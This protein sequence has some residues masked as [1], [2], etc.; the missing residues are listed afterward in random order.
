MRRHISALSSK[1]VWDKAFSI[2]R[3][4]MARDRS[5]ATGY[6]RTGVLIL[7]DESALDGFGDEGNYRI[8]IPCEGAQLT[9]NPGSLLEIEPT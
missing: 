5:R 6:N 3:V 8:T 9:G 4:G 1:T 7:G 2:G